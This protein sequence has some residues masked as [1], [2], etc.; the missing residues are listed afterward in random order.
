MKKQYT[1]PTM[2]VYPLLQQPQILAGSTP[3]S[4]DWLNYTPTIGNNDKNL[5]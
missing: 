1:K 4:D 2:K 5:T 3:T